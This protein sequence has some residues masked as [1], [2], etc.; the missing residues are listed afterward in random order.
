MATGHGPSLAI[1]LRP[2]GVS[3]IDLQPDLELTTDQAECLLEAWLKEPV[4]CS[5]ILRLQGG[6]VNTVLQLEF[7]RPPHQAVVKLHGSNGDSFAAE[8]RALEY[9]GAETSCPVPSVY[10]QDS[11]AR[12]IPYVF[13]LIERVPGVCLKSV[14]LEP[15][16]RAD[17]ETQ[18]ADVLGELHNH[19]GTRWGVIDTDDLS[20]TWAELFVARLVAARAHP[21]IAA[22]LAPGVLAQVD[23]AIDLARP[24]L[25]DSPSPTLVHGDIW[26]G[27]L[28]VALEHG[29]WRL[30]GLLDPDLQFA[31][32]EYE[33]AYLEVFNTPRQDFFG[34][35]GDYHALRSGY[36]HRRLFYWLH[37][38]LVH[39][40]LFGDEFFCD[41]TGRTAG[42]IGRGEPPRRAER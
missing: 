34:A 35:Y 8:A 19:T 6:L 21:A 30:T 9:L 39:V 42:K 16:D 23:E 12:L 37:T 38:A 36:E 29:R 31:D 15:T 14:D 18:L 41:F 3:V 22:R 2:A 13:L 20:E 25:R 33:L 4:V 7:D 26:D 27:N 32:V 17:I 28:M 10:R 11:S 40:A 5:R 1:V 24:A